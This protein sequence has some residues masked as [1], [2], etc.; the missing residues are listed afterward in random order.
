MVNPSHRLAPALGA[1]LVLGL[2]PGWPGQGPQFQDP[3]DPTAPFPRPGAYAGAARCIE[4]HGRQERKLRTAP[5]AAILQVDALPGCETCHGPGQAHSDHPD[6]DIRLITLPPRLDVA[7]QTAFCGRCHQDQIQHHHGDPAG[8][9]AAGIACTFCH[10]VHRDHEPGP[11]PGVTFTARIQAAQQA[12]PVGAARCVECHPLRDQTLASSVHAALAA[13]HRQDGCETCH[14][15]GSLHAQSFGRARLITRPDRAADGAA[16]CRSCHQDV[17]PIAFHWRDRKAPLLSAGVT[18]TTCHLVHAPEDGRRHAW[19]VDPAPATNRTCATC[20]APALCVLPGTVHDELGRLD[21]PL[22]QGCG[23]CHAGALDH[24][25]SGGRA[26]LVRALHHAPAAEQAGTCLQC[27]DGEAALAHV[28]R[29]AHHRNGVSCL[30]CHSPATPRGRDAVAADAERRCTECHAEVGAQFA[31]PNRHPV[32]EGRMRCTSCHEVHG[33]RHKVRDLELAE[34]TCAGCH[35][36]YAGPFVFEHQAG[37]REGCVVCHAPHGSPN[38][39]MLH[40]ATT[41]QNC[42]QCHGDFPAFHDQTPGALFTNCVRCHTEVHGSNHSR[43][44]FR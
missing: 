36:R 42:L 2:L 20:H 16:T 23:S 30:D 44:L 18:C 41:Q 28:T 38:R 43:F 31:L 27:H 29:G 40:Q 21:T 4:C 12:E 17:D 14:G 7:Q 3:Q 26:D 39:R 5:H 9:R 8:F 33:A 13:A 11:L 19:R 10:E 1:C 34:T 24:A 22:E 25:L 37:R 35:P 15:N 6:N 32:P